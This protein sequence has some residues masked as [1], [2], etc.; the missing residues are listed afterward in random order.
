MDF[1]HFFIR[2]FKNKRV[3]KFFMY[4]VNVNFYNSSYVEF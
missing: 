4:S 2:F 3:L 1:Y